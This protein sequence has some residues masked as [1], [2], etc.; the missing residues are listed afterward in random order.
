MGGASEFCKHEEKIN[1]ITSKQLKDPSQT[2]ENL[3]KKIDSKEALAKRLQLANFSKTIIQKLNS[4][5]LAA[6]QESLK[7]EASLWKQSFK[8]IQK[9]PNQIGPSYVA[10]NFGLPEKSKAEPC[11]VHSRREFLK[12]LPPEERN[13]ILTGDPDKAFDPFSY[14]WCYSYPEIAA[15]NPILR[16]YFQHILQFENDIAVPQ[17]PVPVKRPRGRPL[18]S[19][20]KPKVQ[21]PIRDRRLKRTR[22]QYEGSHNNDNLDS[23]CAVAN[24]S[25]RSNSP[26]GQWTLVDYRK[27]GPTKSSGHIQKDRRVCDRRGISP[28]THP[29]ALRPT[30]TS[31][32]PSNGHHQKVRSEHT[33]RDLN[34]LPQRQHIPGRGESTGICNP[35]DSS[36]S[37]CDKQFGSNFGTNQSSNNVS[38]ISTSTST[39]PNIQTIRIH[40]WACRDS[41][42][43]GQCSKDFEHRKSES[44]Q[45]KR[46]TY[47]NTHSRNTGK[48]SESPGPEILGQRENDIGSTEIQP[49]TTGISSQQPGVPNNG[50]S[51]NSINNST[52]S[53]NEQA[54]NRS[55]A[56]A[57]SEQDV[58]LLKHSSSTERHAINDQEISGPVPNRTIILLPSRRHDTEPVFARPNGSP[59][60]PASIFSV[61]AIPNCQ[62]N[63][64]QH[65]NDAKRERR[66]DCSGSRAPVSTSDPDRPSSLPSVRDLLPVLGQTHN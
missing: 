10:D 38:Y 60:E 51:K 25:S 49:G 13:I 45:P 34:A 1:L 8:F 27:S 30:S 35:T 54:L 31:S 26:N 12:L 55:S 61:G 36:E 24:N 37:V 50:R 7:N 23:I 63:Q 52:A 6:L 33:S 19:K 66:F 62:L 22:S 65:V 32:K 42:C 48:P 40:I 11:W 14:I 18:G 15:L 56:G 57:H 4:E 5:Q 17:P 47:F 41:L 43:H 29:G 9:E 46:T 39:T 2:F 58:Q 20:N 64:E 3:I 16:Q 59:K 28:R 53:P 44:A 21:A